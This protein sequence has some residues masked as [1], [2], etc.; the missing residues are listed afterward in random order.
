MLRIIYGADT[1]TAHEALRDLLATGGSYSAEDVQWMDGKTTTPEE[2]LQACEQS[3]MFAE[4]RLIVVEGLL[5]RFSKDDSGKKP[6]KVKKRGQKAQGMG[7]WEAFVERVPGLSEKSILVLLD[8]D[9][10]AVN[11]LLKGLS[12]VAGGVTKCEPLKRDE[13]PRWVEQRRKAGFWLF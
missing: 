7:E 11:P 2:I 12:S 8:A 6:A 5:S 13:L 3:S 10:K 4:T 9:L 1:F